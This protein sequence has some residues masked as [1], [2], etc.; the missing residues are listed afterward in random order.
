MSLD[1]FS[2]PNFNASPVSHSAPGIITQGV[3]QQLAG[4]KPWVRFMAVLMFV[5]AGFM[6]LGALVMLVAG[7]AIAAS[8]KAPG[9]S[10]GMIAGI[11]VL[12]GLFSLIYIYPALKLWKFADRI[13]SLMVSGDVLDLEAALDQQRAF[14]KF[15]GI[16]V[17]VVFVLYIVAVIAVVIFSVFAAATAKGLQPVETAQI[18]LHLALPY[19]I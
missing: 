2:S 12:Y 17:I 14:W 8:G 19:R 9:F 13:A 11:A 15:L 10:T 18:P 4:T 16:M 5:G 1:P 7:G 6:L 3:I